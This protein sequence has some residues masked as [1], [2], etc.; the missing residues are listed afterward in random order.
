MKI[1]LVMPTVVGRGSG[2]GNEM[3]VW[4][5]A[6]IIAQ[7]LG[8]RCLHP[9]WGLNPRGYNRYFYTSRF[10]VFIYF[11]LR[12]ILP[13]VNFSESDY[14]NFGGDSLFDAAARFADYH[15]LNKRR[16][17]IITVSG[18]WGGYDLLAS[19]RQPLLAKLLPTRNTATNLAELYSKLPPDKLTV[20]MHIRRGDF[21]R[22]EHDQSYQG[23]FNVP[24]KLSWYVEIAQS[25]CTAFGDSVSF[26]VISD[27][28]LEELS[29]ITQLPNVFTTKHQSM[30]DVSDLIAL[31]NCDLLVCS[32]SS[33]SL[34]AAFLSKGR[35]IWYKPQLGMKQKYGAIWSHEHLQAASEGQT[36]LSISSVE[37]LI[38]AGNRVEY[39]GVAVSDD[40][41]ISREVIDYLEVVLALKRRETDLVRYGVTAM[42]TEI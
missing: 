7:A 27:A 2:L 14:I 25:I 10:D 28:P 36:Q 33:Y 31:T 41:K 42:K 18:M 12:K 23:K 21:G 16:F 8:A 9:A 34:W 4:G 30:S 32:I 35:Y 22:P 15:N 29:E 6:M 11:L 38:A 37:Q 13:V 19:A 26:I 24:I 5:K 3:V 20:G 1:K 17:F 40:G 39:R